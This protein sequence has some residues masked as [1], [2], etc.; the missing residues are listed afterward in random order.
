MGSQ[1]CTS[2]LIE[3]THFV[4]PIVTIFCNSMFIFYE[5][6]SS[7]TIEKI[8]EFSVIEEIWLKAFKQQV[9]FKHQSKLGVYF[10]HYQQTSLFGLWSSE[11]CLYKQKIKT[12][13]RWDIVGVVPTSCAQVLLLFIYINIALF[14]RWKSISKW[15]SCFYTYSGGQIRIPRQ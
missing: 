9:F 1:Q 15:V 4:F 7:K 5:A 2:T 6:F 8:E 12:N 3:S 13:A 10:M 14:I 11:F